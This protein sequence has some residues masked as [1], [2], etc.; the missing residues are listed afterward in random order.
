M[1]STSIETARR[2]WDRRRERRRAVRIDLGLFMLAVTVRLAHLFSIRGSDFFTDLGLDRLAYDEWGRQ[3]AS[4]HWLGTEIFYQDPLYPYLL[5]VFYSLAG[6]RLFLVVTVQ[7]ILGSLVPIFVHRTSRAWFSPAAAVTAGLLAAVYGPAIYY[8]G[9]ILKTSL[10]AFLVAATLLAAS[11]A[12]RRGGWGPWGLT[13]CLLGLGGLVR[14]NLLLFLPVLAAWV[15]LAR[16]PGT[17]TGAESSRLA[18]RLAARAAER[19]RWAQ[20]GALAA[21]ITLILLPTAARN[22]LVGGEW[23]LTTAQAGPNFYLGNNPANS[24]GRYAPLPFVGANPRYERL[25][26]TREAERRTGRHLSPTEVSHFWF[27]ESGRWMA[28]YPGDWLRLMARKFRLFWSAYE[29]PDNLDYALYRRTAP[30]LA[31][32]LPGFG[33]VAPLGLIGL[34]MAR[35][36]AG[37]PRVL[38]LFVA[39][40][41]FSVILFFVFSRYRFPLLP[42]LFPLAGCALVEVAKRIRLIG[43]GRLPWRSGGPFL[44]AVAGVAAAVNLPVHAPAQSPAMAIARA[45]HL[46]RVVESSATGHFNLG[47][48]F[49]RRAET[50]KNRDALLESAAREFTQAARE[51]PAAAAPFADLGKVLARLGRDA[52]AIEAYRATLRLDPDRPRPHHVLGM[53]YRRSGQLDAAAREFHRALQLAPDRL[54]S[55]VALGNVHLQQGNFPAAA[56]AFRQALDIDPSSEAARDGLARATNAP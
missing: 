42:A 1:Q 39:T 37:G 10:G 21:G 20:V 41:S 47:L 29:V 8:D 18:R 16:P 38:I 40:Y 44:L 49:A 12:I 53:L 28:S 34:W 35:R 22:R 15:L 23:V 48:S 19:R 3:L 5:G 54:D 52:E 33:L 51:D 46:P 17:V 14:G 7:S 6:H 45:L 25:G 31:L 2:G 4:G 27:A 50:A 26:F 32:P 43:T 24:S 36:R 56:T 30:V 11:S 9:L 13:G 55:A